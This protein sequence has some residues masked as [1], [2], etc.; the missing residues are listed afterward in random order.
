[1]LDRLIIRN[2]KQFE[3]VDIDLGQAVVFVGPNNAGK[4]SAL[5]ALALWELG[6]RRWTEKRSGKTPPKKRSGVTMNRRDLVALPVPETN[7]LWRDLHVRG[8]SRQDGK[9]KTENIRVEIEVHGIFDG[10]KWSNGLEF[11]YANAESI[12]CRPLGWA[13]GGAADA[14][15]IGKAAQSVRI[16]YLPP[17]S[18]L[19]SNELRMDP[20][21]IQVRLGEGRTAEVLRNLCHSLAEGPE[22]D[23]RWLMLEERIRNLFG[24]KLHRPEYIA[25]RGELTME[26][27]DRRSVKLDLSAAGRGLQQTLLL[28]A[29][30]LA[31]PGCVLLLDEPDA[32]LEI[33]R[34][35]QIYGTLT[36]VA[37]LS[38]SQI[39]AASHSEVIL[40]EAADRD[41]VVAFVGKPHRIDDRGSQVLKSLKSIGFDQY[42]LAEEAGWVLY[43]EGATDLA[44]L[45]ALAKT[46]NHQAAGHLE[47]PFT[48]YILNQPGRAH[49][50]LY[51]LR[52]AK[53]DLVGLAVMDNFG[54]E[55]QGSTQLPIIQWK[56]REIENYL[57][58]PIVLEDYAANLAAERSVGPLFESVEVAHFR[59][60]MHRCVE[61]RVPPVALRNLA[62]RWWDTVKASDDYLDPVFE[63]FFQELGLPNL[64]RKSDYHRLA[65]LVPAELIDPEVTLVLDRI[66]EV[67]NSAN[68]AGGGIE[69]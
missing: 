60:V 34:Q 23:S 38:G 61:E 55:A 24:V 8:V 37:R 3:E 11:D 57:C 25:E 27:T 59:D 9:T 47:R 67:A 63:S 53:P 58:F 7:L 13:S 20:G 51:G 10:K 15:P 32:H 14:D 33:L 29:F 28:L 44:I 19:I 65:D 46:L 5:Q 64:M 40:N 12:Y 31:N 62:D 52:E 17:M 22:G 69:L 45:R 18:G 42:Y 30:L 21:A 48:H 4:T 1:M 39:I 6:V 36:D 54:R 50:H 49:E 41:V 26:Y 66:V 35:R 2:F 68:P 56:K 43:L 16:A